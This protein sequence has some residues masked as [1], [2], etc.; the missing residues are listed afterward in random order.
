MSAR[1]VLLLAVCTLLI[2]ALLA[3]APASARPKQRDPYSC[4]G[5]WSER[6]SCTLRS[7]GT[8]GFGLSGWAFGDGVTYVV[9]RMF[10]VRPDGTEKLIGT[11][12]IAGATTSGCGQVWASS[13]RDFPASRGA[14]LRCRV[15]GTPGG[16]YT[17]SG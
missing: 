2:L 7:S 6:A 11:C 8:G 16:R 15:Q 1:R 13:E 4:G 3:P 9:V 17:C 12:A 10:R 14:L 5:A